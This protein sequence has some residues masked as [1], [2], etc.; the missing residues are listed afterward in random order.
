MTNKTSKGFYAKLAMTNMRK[1]AKVYLPFLVTCVITVMMFYI[2]CA[3]AMGTGMEGMSYPATSQS[4]MM[5]GTWIVAIFAA[6][7]LFYTN[8]FL[9]KR[10]RKEF[11]L[12]NIL[13]MEKKHLSRV[14][15]YETVYTAIISLLVGLSLGVFFGQLCALLL[16]KALNI[17]AEMHLFFN[18]IAVLTTIIVLGVIFLLIMFSSIRHIVVSKPVELMRGGEKGEKE[19]K[20]RWLLAV[21]GVLFLAGGYY[22][23]LSTESALKAI[24]LFFLAVVMVIIGTYLLFSAVSIAVLKIMRNNKKYYYKPQHFISVSG[25]IYRMKQNAVGLAN[26]CILSTMVIV[27]LSITL[28]LYFGIDA[29]VNTVVPRHVQVM[30]RGSLGENP[31][32]IKQAADE[33]A[34]KLNTVPKNTLEIRKLYTG[35]N[36]SL[37]EKN[38]VI[39]VDPIGE[40]SKAIYCTFT[41]AEDFEEATGVHVDVAEG[42]AVVDNTMSNET[43]YSKIEIGDDISINVRS[44]RGLAKEAYGKYLTTTYREDIIIVHDDDELNRIMQSYKKIID[45]EEWFVY[46]LNYEY[47]F[48][49]DGADQ[50]QFANLMRSYMSDLDVDTVPSV[51]T[52]EETRS[53]YT[54]LFGGLLFIGVFL[55][56][57][58]AMAAVLIIYYKQISEGYDDR[59]RYEIMRNVG[60]D[61][62]Q[63]KKSIHSQILSVFFMP[64]ITAGMHTLFAFPIVT[65]MISALLVDDGMLYMKITLAVFAVFAVLYAIV[66]A[67]SAKTYYKITASKEN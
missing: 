62:S 29:A 37:D 5:M 8:S 43:G 22:I 51:Y 66:Y 38:A 17:S 65:L 28:S 59:K 4:M 54:S 14:I 26:I 45:E 41:T 12:Y 46:T 42:E 2:V 55:S 61:K 67:L 57:L 40:E 31:E 1:N 60:M 33:C 35:S 10:R 27:M 50:E 49:I 7:F 32:I 13:G 58:F 9:M 15:A 53:E 23:S 56:I 21:L 6:I 52:R 30:T 20:T 16:Q 36:M 25:M 64:L 3:L 44:Q 18:P 11:G 63:V 24:T 47:D 39:K 19:P 48:D 34:K